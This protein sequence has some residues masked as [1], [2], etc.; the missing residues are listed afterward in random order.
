[1]HF[2]NLLRSTSRVDLKLQRAALGSSFS[3]KVARNF[4]FISKH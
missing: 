4:P 3:Y 1:M 2:S